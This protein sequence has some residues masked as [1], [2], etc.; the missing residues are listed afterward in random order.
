MARNVEHATRKWLMQAIVSKNMYGKALC[1]FA[2]SVVNRNGLRLSICNER[3]ESKLLDCVKSELNLIYP[4][5]TSVNTE[6]SPETTLIVVPHM[7][8]N[9]YRSMIHTSWKIM[10]I[11]SSVDR[12]KG[13]VQVVNFH[14]QAVHSLFSEMPDNPSDYTIRAPYPVFHLLREEDILKAVQSSYPSPEEIPSRNAKHMY[15]LGIH[16]CQRRF[17]GLFEAL[18]PRDPKV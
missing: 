16:A 2:S 10:E 3:D 18:S 14:P 13:R 8:E 5:L 7:F 15:E 17:Q 4:A 6:S 9:S 12:F 1:P 11:V